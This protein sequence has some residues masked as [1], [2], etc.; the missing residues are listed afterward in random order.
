MRKINLR[1]SY[2]IQKISFGNYTRMERSV[3]RIFQPSQARENSDLVY[4]SFSE[5]ICYRKESLDAPVA[6]LPGCL[7]TSL[8]GSVLYDTNCLLP[9]QEGKMRTC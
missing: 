1:K 4:F 8:L 7:F 3:S 2:G 9:K 6:R 5:Q